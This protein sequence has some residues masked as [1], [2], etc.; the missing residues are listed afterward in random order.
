MTK[1]TRTR[2][3]YILWMAE[4]THAFHLV[5][6]SLLFSPLTALLFSLASPVSAPSLFNSF[7]VV[8][9]NSQLSTP[10]LNSPTPALQLSS[11]PTLQFSNCSQLLYQ[12]MYQILHQLRTHHLVYVALPTIP[13]VH[14]NHPT[15]EISFCYFNVA[16]FYC[17]IIAF[18]NMKAF[19]LLYKNSLII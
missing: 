19:C 14:P 7:I 4:E 3:C 18:I 17:R 15:K 11:S 2:R 16:F 5:N 8:A 6:F 10:T 13:V 1:T 9:T 12:I